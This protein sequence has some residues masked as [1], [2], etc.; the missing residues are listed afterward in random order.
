MI[1]ANAAWFTAHRDD[2]ILFEGYCDERG[3]AAYNLALGER[4]AKVSMSYLTGQ[5]VRTDRI[6]LISYG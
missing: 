3:T 2:L 5:G 4:R 1:D 6:T